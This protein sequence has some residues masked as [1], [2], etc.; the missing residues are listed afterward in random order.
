[1]LTMVER[2]QAV[3]PVKEEEE[4]VLLNTPEDCGNE[5]VQRE[6]AWGGEEDYIPLRN[7]HEGSGEGGGVLPQRAGT[8]AALVSNELE[9]ALES[10]DWRRDCPRPSAMHRASGYGGSD[11]WAR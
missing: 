1:M 7:L 9:G 2:V 10:K 6:D 11:W 3:V 4:D 5:A 8:P